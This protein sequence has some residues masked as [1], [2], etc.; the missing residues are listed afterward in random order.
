MTT[1][2]ERMNGRYENRDTLRRMPI[3]IGTRARRSVEQMKRY[4]GGGSG[5][6]F[7]QASRNMREVFDAANIP[8][9]KEQ[10]IEDKNRI[11][12]EEAINN[13]PDLPGNL[14]YENEQARLRV[15]KDRLKKTQKMSLKDFT[16]PP[17]GRS[18]YLVKHLNTFEINRTLIEEDLAWLSHP[19]RI[20][21]NPRHAQVPVERQNVF[22]A[23]K[24][25][26]AELTLLNTP[27]NEHHFAKKYG[28]V[29]AAQENIRNCCNTTHESIGGSL[30]F[31]LLL[32]SGALAAIWGIVDIKKKQV[33]LRTIAMVGAMGALLQKDTRFNYLSSDQFKRVSEKLGAEGIE[34]L[35]NLARNGSGPFNALVRKM[36]EMTN[37]SQAIN[38][39]TVKQLVESGV[40]EDVAKS[41]V[42]LSPGDVHYCLLR[43]KATAK[44]EDRRL[45]PVFADA[46]KNKTTIVRDLKGL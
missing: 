12:T 11:L 16:K 36:K 32:G 21:D 15:I 18:V 14:D 8:R 25:L 7:I 20:Q 41:L 9:T 1:L 42:G 3:Y 29:I 30:K 34:A 44:S 46:N 23:Y 6:D 13:L 26:L 27:A 37:Y 17:A 2:P 33:S 38:E 45:V 39:N 31:L 28:S 19:N 5:L 24:A 40:K 10:M 35:Q 22:R 4:Y 43:L